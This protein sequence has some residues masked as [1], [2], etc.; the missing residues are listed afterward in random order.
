[1][2]FRLHLDRPRNDA[3]ASAR[4]SPQAIGLRRAGGGRAH[5]AFTGRARRAFTL[6]ELLVVVAIIGILVGLLLPAVQAAREN[7][8]ST[9]CKNS[10][11]QIGLAM[12]RYC[13]DHGGYF[14]ATAH[15]VDE[16]YSWINTLAPYHE[17]VDSLRICPKDP[18][19]EERLTIRS[20]SY[21]INGYIAI[22]DRPDS[23][24]NFNHIKASSRT[25]TVFEGADSRFVEFYNEHTHSYSW[26]TKANIASKQVWKSVS[27]ELQTD[28][29]HLAAN[30]LFG[31]G[32]VETIPAQ[33][34]QGWC[35]A[36]YN[37]ARPDP[38]NPPP[39]NP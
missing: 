9:H 35:D 16:Q 3:I 22:D 13:D 11:R 31:D 37:F 12:L 27:G 20:T 39:T 5:R 24:R 28:R 25:M 26:F 23:V 38:E 19:A 7:A 33:T 14:P 36:S 30:Y 1:M 17:D 2:A 6:V 32:H 4:I 34:I 8:R 18:W 21:A 10:L 29:H 15:S